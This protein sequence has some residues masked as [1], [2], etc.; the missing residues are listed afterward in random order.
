MAV[1]V[2]NFDPEALGDLRIRRFDGAVSWKYL[3]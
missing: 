2:R 3:D 1:N